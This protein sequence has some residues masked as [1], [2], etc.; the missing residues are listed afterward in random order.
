MQLNQFR[1]AGLSVT[2]A[3]TSLT[4]PGCLSRTRR[5]SG[6][7]Q[8]QHMV[9]YRSGKVTNIQWGCREDVRIS[10]D[11]QVVYKDKNERSSSK[12]ANLV[13]IV[14][15]IR[16]ISRYLEEKCFGRSRIRKSKI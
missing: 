16:D 12:R 9:K 15:H 1:A 14:L 10:N 7:F 13:G 6:S 3:N 8:T 11:M 4:G 2:R 5:K